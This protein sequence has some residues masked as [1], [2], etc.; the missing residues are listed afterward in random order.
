MITA[1]KLLPW[2]NSRT[3]RAIKFKESI[4]TFLYV[5]AVMTVALGALLLVYTYFKWI[6]LH[7]LLWVIV[8][9]FIEFVSLSGTM[10]CTLN[11]CQWAGKDR[12][13]GEILYINKKTRHQYV[14]EGLLMA[15]AM[16]SV[17]LLLILFISLPKL[18]LNAYLLPSNRI[19]FWRILPTLGVSGWSTSQ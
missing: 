14:S 19:A 4:Y 16:L 6:V 10:Y 2:I 11:G 7:P 5:F 17:S 15:T 1:R 8:F 9:Y 13:T 3:K 18:R 12:D